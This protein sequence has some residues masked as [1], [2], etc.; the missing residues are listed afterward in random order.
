VA[1]AEISGGNPAALAIIDLLSKGEC[2]ETRLKS[3]RQIVDWVVAYTQHLD[4]NDVEIRAELSRGLFNVAL[5]LDARGLA[6]EEE[7]LW[8]AIRMAAVFAKPEGLSALTQFLSPQKL[9]HVQQVSLQAIVNVSQR[10]PLPDIPELKEL[11]RLVRDTANRLCRADLIGID[12][13]G[14]LA[15]SS[16]AAARALALPGISVWTAAFRTRPLLLRQVE[17]ELAELVQ[18]WPESATTGQVAAE[19]RTARRPRPRRPRLFIGQEFT[20][21][22]TQHVW[23]VTD[24]GV[25][26]VI[27]IDVTETLER[28]GGDRS[29]LGGPPYLTT[30][31]VWSEQDLQVLEGVE[32]IEWED[33]RGSRR[34]NLV[35]C[36]HCGWIDPDSLLAHAGDEGTWD[37]DCVVCSR[38]FVATRIISERVV[39]QR[40][41]DV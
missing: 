8:A 32:G 30:E 16:V 2:Y 37:H 18:Q 31:Q 41:E 38:G 15:I 20:H 40:R 27:A 19:P 33:A 12:G 28:H 39:C 6:R 11:R 36:P 17:N 29:W 14:A 22:D 4:V 10:R 34:T 5:E 13:V 9:C 25:Y 7:T 35:V 26:S 1:L 21:P 23:R 3:G 24:I